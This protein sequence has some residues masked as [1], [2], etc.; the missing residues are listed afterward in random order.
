MRAWGGIAGW[1]V[2][3]GLVTSVLGPGEAGAVLAHVKPMNGT[4]TVD[5]FAMT[6]EDAEGKQEKRQV[7]VSGSAAGGTLDLSPGLYRY[8]LSGPGLWPSDGSFTVGNQPDFNVIVPAEPVQATD[9]WS[10]IFGAVTGGF[11]YQFQQDGD[12]SLQKSVTT[13]TVASTGSKFVNRLDA[14]GL[15][16]ANKNDTNKLKLSFL[17]A[18]F[19]VGLPA[20][21]GL[22]WGTLR[23]G[24]GLS[25]GAMLARVDVDDRR[26]GGPDTTEVSGNGFGWGFDYTLTATQRPRDDFLSRLGARINVAYS[27]ARTGAD[28]SPRDSGGLDRLNATVGDA[29]ESTLKV[30]RWH[31]G[32]DVLFRITDSFYAFGGVK[33]RETTARVSTTNPVDVPGPGPVTRQISQRYSGDAVLGRFGFDA[34][35]HKDHPQCPLIFARLEGE[36]SGSGDFGAMFKLGMGFNTGLWFLAPV[37]TR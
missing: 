9:F 12:L 10:P 35:H 31:V 37:K 27:Y 32:G 8:K 18:N 20:P 22:G 21:T 24:I 33:Y 36:V 29:T 16:D 25:L 34:V 17:G 7:E 26:A 23:H 5:T 1:A 2:V 30:D 14:A 3:G 11:Q 19:N 15:H 4:M 28:R 6:L 13:D